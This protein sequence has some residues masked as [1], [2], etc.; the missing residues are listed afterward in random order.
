MPLATALVVDWAGIEPATEFWLGA[1]PLA[2]SDQ[3]EIIEAP[4]LRAALSL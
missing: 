3:P 2:T 1:I 4:S